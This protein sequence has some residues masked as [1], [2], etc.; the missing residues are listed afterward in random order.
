MIFGG[1]LTT[2]GLEIGWPDGRTEIR[3]EGRHRRFTAKLEQVSYNGRY[4]LERGQEV[5]FVTERAV[6]RLQPQGLALIEIAPGLDVQ[7]DVLGNME[8][9]PFL[10]GEPKEM[11]PRLFRPEV[12]GLAADL[13]ARPGYNIPPRVKELMGDQQ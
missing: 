13:A 3:R 7:K 11:E 10:P 2:G 8:F 1:T 9:R 5:L 6:F 12:M 4:A